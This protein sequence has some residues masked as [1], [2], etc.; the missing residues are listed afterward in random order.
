MVSRDTSVIKCGL[1]NIQSVTNKTQEIRDLIKENGYDI[2]RL[3]ETWLSECD[4][5]KIID[6][7][8]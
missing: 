8:T 4:H 1:V 3:T 7:R 6:Q 5:A 2:L